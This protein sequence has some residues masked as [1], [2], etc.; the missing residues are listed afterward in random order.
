MDVIN[1]EETKLRNIKP[2]VVKKM[3]ISFQIHIVTKVLPLIDI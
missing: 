2:Y 3:K 1:K